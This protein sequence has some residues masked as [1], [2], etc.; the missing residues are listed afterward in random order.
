MEH[1]ELP[2]GI[3][4]FQR[5]TNTWATCWSDLVS[6][7]FTIIGILMLI[8]LCAGVAAGIVLLVRYLVKRRDCRAAWVDGYKWCAHIHKCSDDVETPK[9]VPNSCAGAWS[10]GY[11]ACLN[12]NDLVLTEVENQALAD[13]PFMNNNNKK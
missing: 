13:N 12:A 6:S 8:I 9:Q 3:D 5:S 1:I 10:E 11:V 4:Y 2:G 7:V